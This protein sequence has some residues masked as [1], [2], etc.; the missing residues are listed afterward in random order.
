MLIRGVFT[1]DRDMLGIAKL[2]TTKPSTRDKDKKEDEKP[3]DKLPFALN[4]LLEKKKFK[5]GIGELFVK[6][7]AGEAGE[8]EPDLV[9]QPT[10]PITES[11]QSQPPVT[12]ETVDEVQHVNH[13]KNLQKKVSEQIGKMVEQSMGV[14]LDYE[15]A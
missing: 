4:Y 2:I 5:E 14:K 8:D 11:G 6:F 9:K 13:T 10:K 1:N 12:V 15:K 7:M 3:L